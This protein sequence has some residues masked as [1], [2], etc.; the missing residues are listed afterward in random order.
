MASYRYRAAGP[1]D[2]K[3]LGFIIEDVGQ[4][5]AV[6]AQ[7]DRVD[8]Y[9]YASIA[10]AALQVQAKQIESLQAEVAALRREVGK[11]GAVRLPAGQPSL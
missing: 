10:V 11:V 8:L 1:E 4:S 5:A 9:G 2:R 3:H 7:R 6:D